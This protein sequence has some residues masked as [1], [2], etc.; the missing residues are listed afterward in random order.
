VPHVHRLSIGALP[1]RKAHPVERH[2]RPTRLG[3]WEGIEPSNRRNS[4]L[5]LVGLVV[6]FP[7]LT[8]VNLPGLDACRHPR[9]HT[10]IELLPLCDE[11]TQQ[12]AVFVDE[13]F[14]HRLHHILCKLRFAQHR[15]VGVRYC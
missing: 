10:H 11:L 1:R 7:T 4:A 15:R 8:V 9:R 13:R 3:V 12:T 6:V 14:G 5:I 2:Q